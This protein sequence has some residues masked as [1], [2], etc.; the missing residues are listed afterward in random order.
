MP[1]RADELCNAES[2]C[3]WRLEMPEKIADIFAEQAAPT[4]HCQIRD[5]GWRCLT[6]RKTFSLK[7]F[8]T[9]SLEIEDQDLIIKPKD[10][11]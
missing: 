2:A 7:S 5:V 9:S 8:R 10:H 11:L 1:I 3:L 6:F 4:W